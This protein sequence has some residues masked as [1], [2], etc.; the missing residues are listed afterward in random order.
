MS[1]TKRGLGLGLV[2]EMHKTF[3]HRARRREVVIA[4][5]GRLRRCL[6]QRTAGTMIKSFMHF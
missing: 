2:L 5:L 1:R 3:N 4:S 6:R